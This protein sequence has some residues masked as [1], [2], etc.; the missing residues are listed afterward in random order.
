MKTHI[1][2]KKCQVFA[3]FIDKKKETEEDKEQK[4]YIGPEVVKKAPLYGWYA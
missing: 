2:K 1:F 4:R 3:I